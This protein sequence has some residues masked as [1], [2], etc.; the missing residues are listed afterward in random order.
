MKKKLVFIVTA[1]I[2]ITA[3]STYFFNEYRTKILVQE[4]FNTEELGEEIHD[5]NILQIEEK[6]VKMTTI[7]KNNLIY[8]DLVKSIEDLKIK[9]D[10]SSDFSYS[11]EY[12]LSFMYNNSSYHIL[13][14]EKG[15]LRYEG[16]SYKIQGEDSIEELFEI[17]KKGVQ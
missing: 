3:V 10:L 6:E 14:N 16:E 1:F 2:L 5:I 12:R 7:E 13:V 4:F 17:I 8:H 15:A 11:E 9:K